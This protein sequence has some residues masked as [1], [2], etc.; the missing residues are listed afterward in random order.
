[1]STQVNTQPVIDAPV[2]RKRRFHLAQTNM[3]LVV[4]VGLM[5]CI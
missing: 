2:E 1:M 4:G 3:T 5:R